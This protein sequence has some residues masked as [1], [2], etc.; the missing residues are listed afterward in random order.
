MKILNKTKNELKIELSGEGHTFCNIIQKTLLKDEK[1][2]LAGYDISHPLTSDPVIYLRTQ[3]R[4]KPEIVLLNTVK[5]I[6]NDSEEF[7][8]AFN[9]ALKEWQR[10]QN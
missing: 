1:V 10:H 8:V 3:K 2:D 4:V 5:K 9:K 7:R 6:H